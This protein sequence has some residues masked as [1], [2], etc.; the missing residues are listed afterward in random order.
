MKERRTTQ[1][2]HMT[3]PLPMCRSSSNLIACECTPCNVSTFHGASR[4]MPSISFGQVHNAIARVG[5]SSSSAS[6]D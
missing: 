6:D 4:L 3:V 5:V 2:I 1:S